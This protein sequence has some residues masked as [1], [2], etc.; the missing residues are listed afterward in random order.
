MTD[1]RKHLFSLGSMALVLASTTIAAGGKSATTPAPLP[2]QDP[3]GPSMKDM[4]CNL[5]RGQLAR[6]EA[7]VVTAGDYVAWVGRYRTPKAE[8]DGSVE[9][10][11]QGLRTFSYGP[12]GSRWSACYGKY[13]N[14]CA[15]QCFDGGTTP[16]V[17]PGGCR[18]SFCKRGTRLI[19]NIATESPA[20]EALMNTST[21][22]FAVV[23][24]LNE[25]R[26]RY[27]RELGLTG[28]VGDDPDVAILE[29]EAVNVRTSL[30]RQV[31]AARDAVARACNR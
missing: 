5:Q 20:T 31:P 4:A 10:C 8:L 21:R 22:K 19:Q 11:F 17:D 13:T 23:T 2:P 29:R 27:R 9:A 18:E 6:L 25:D 1:L 24:T 16:P 7:K 26:D 30:E 12:V 15:R 3:G 14:P 28:W